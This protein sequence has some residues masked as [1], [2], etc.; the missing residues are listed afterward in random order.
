MRTYG[1]GGGR[2]MGY[3][4]R[5]ERSA[6]SPLVNNLD[7]LP[8]EEVTQLLLAGEDHVGQL[9]VDP[10]LLLGCLRRVPLRKPHLALSAHQQHELD[11]QRL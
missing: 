6:V 2:V 4:P 1:E 10:R 7:V 5:S 9:A 11:L 3:S 8:L